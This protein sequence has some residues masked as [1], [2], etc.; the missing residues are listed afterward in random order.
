MLDSDVNTEGIE[1]E[2]VELQ[3]VPV[4]TQIAEPK[5]I[6]T[7]VMETPVVDDIVKNI[8]DL[9]NDSIKEN[10][11]IKLTPYEVN[12]IKLILANSPQS[13]LDMEN[14]ISSIISDNTINASDIPKF[15]TLVK[16]FYIVVKS[17]NASN[18]SLT[19]EQIVNI[20][21]G[22]IK[23]ILPIILKKNN[24][25]SDNIIQNANTIIDTC[26]DLLLIIPDIKK[27]KCSLLCF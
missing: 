25:Y 27:L 10:E 9:I 26:V 17:V 20:S 24:V 16:D 8:I 22:I 4:E 18:T 12:F 21:A 15:I 11:N 14:S 5:D 19:G 13:F 7:Q 3:E 23:F 2:G 6:E 1:A